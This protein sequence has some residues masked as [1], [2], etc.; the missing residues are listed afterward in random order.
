MELATQVLARNR[1]NTHPVN[2]IRIFEDTV[3]WHN[4]H[5]IKLVI[6]C[7]KKVGLVVWIRHA[8]WRRRLSIVV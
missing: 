8:G 4:I 1:G 2:H 7:R 5:E 3:K 6:N